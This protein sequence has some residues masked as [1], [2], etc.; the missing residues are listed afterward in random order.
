MRVLAAVWAREAEGAQA[1]PRFPLQPGH[2]CVCV[3]LDLH[4]RLFS[5]KDPPI[6][7]SEICKPSFPEKEA[8]SQ[9]GNVGPFVAAGS[10]LQD[11]DAQPDRLPLS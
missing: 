4:K 11:C 2:P 6:Q 3:T 5:Q 7:T 1:Q 8:E 9:T 10:R